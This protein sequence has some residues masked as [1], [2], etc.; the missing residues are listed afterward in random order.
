[1]LRS[2]SAW[3]EILKLGNV[4]QV[5]KDQTSFSRGN[6]LRVLATEG[7][8]KYLKEPHSEDEIANHFNYSDKKYLHEI[9]QAFITDGTLKEVEDNKYVFKQ[10]VN[11]DM[12]TPSVFNEQIK[13]IMWNLADGIPSRLRN[14][15]YE[16]TGGINLFN[17]DSALSLKIYK[18]LRN[19]AF[20]YVKKFHN[21][22]SFLDIGAGTGYGTTSIWLNFQEKK[23]TNNI[24]V[25][26]VEPEAYF[27][28]IAK[29]EFER[30]AVKISGKSLGEI[31]KKK[32]SYPEF[33]TGSIT[34]IP[35]DNEFFDYVYAS[36]VLHWTNPKRAIEEMIRV[37][38]PGGIIFGSQI[39]VG[40]THLFTDIHVKV[41]KGANGIF[42][43]NDMKRWA[44]EAG[45]KKVK[46]STPISVFEIWK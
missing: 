20:A 1:M 5:M 13:D 32:D 16:F 25:I 23:D 36:Q 9:I 33:M 44:K 11:T 24:K 10:P 42:T 7:W 29:N 38:K 3:I 6:I 43:K 41:M 30:M 39:F 34:N 35:Y 37:T 15:D 19:S 4:S 28:D 46:F 26:G 22:S 45:A 14:E 8:L 12:A 18:Q 27:I 31:Q 17:W 2:A 40:K 21:H